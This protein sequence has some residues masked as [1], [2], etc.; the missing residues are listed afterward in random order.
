MIDV[1]GDVIKLAPVVTQSCDCIEGI[2]HI[3]FIQNRVTVT[4]TMNVILWEENHY[5]KNRDRTKM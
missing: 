4:I 1:M 5:E 3:G 2:L